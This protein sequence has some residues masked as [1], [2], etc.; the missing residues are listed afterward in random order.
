MVSIIY[1]RIYDNTYAKSNTASSTAIFPSLT[2]KVN[3][4]ITLQTF[5]NTEGLEHELLFTV[6]NKFVPITQSTVWIVNL[7]IYYSKNVWNDNYLIYC[8]MSGT[9]VGCKVSQ[10]T[11]YQI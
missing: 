2:D 8:T 3:S 1:L 10:Y 6:V 9:P 4:L 11:P 7:P 5:F